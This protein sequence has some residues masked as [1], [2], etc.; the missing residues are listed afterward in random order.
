MKRMRI[1]SY[2]SV[3]AVVSVISAEE[4]VKSISLFEAGKLAVEQSKTAKAESLSVVITTARS[5]ENGRIEN[6]EIEAVYHADQSGADD[7]RWEFTA[8]QKIGFEQRAERI[9][10]R[11]EVK[12]SKA[13]FAK[14]KA[15]IRTAGIESAL[16]VWQAEQNLLLM[17]NRA[18]TA[19][20]IESF[21]VLRVKLGYDS[22][23]TAFRAKADRV[24]AE[25]KLKS[26]ESELYR[27]EQ[28]CRN[29]WNQ[30][31]LAF[32]IEPNQ[33]IEPIES[34]AVLISKLKNG[35]GLLVADSQN[36]L[37]DQA[38]RSERIKSIPDVAVVA[39]M[40]KIPAGDVAEISAGIAVELP[41]FSRNRAGRAG[42][43][44]FSDQ[45]KL[46]REIVEQNQKSEL[47]SLIRE[48]ENSR[49]E[50]ISFDET[51]VP[52]SKA[53]YESVLKQYE[54]GR[55]DYRDLAEAEDQFTEVQTNRIETFV[56]TEEVRNQI[57]MIC[58]I[59]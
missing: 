45:A 23:P 51:V 31:E 56:R 20:A 42:A 19:V 13:E 12:L 40:E 18:K 16:A 2:L 14:A 36:D 34:E 25:S 41:I 21:T 5:K 35:T 37:A 26:A 58:G 6:P 30:P 50:L 9:A 24:S 29:L 55:A 27:A 28:T 8:S 54:L 17:K 3:I 1:G 43:Q 52:A 7:N 44:A 4:P 59:E 47:I 57:N 15:E 39:G 10:G 22:E 38:V 32:K 49:N 11:G 48:F 53:Y 46:N 33:T